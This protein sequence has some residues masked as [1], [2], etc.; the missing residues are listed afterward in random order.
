MTLQ[1]GFP[2]TVG[3]PTGTTADFGCYALLV[4]GQNIYAGHHNV[5]QWLNPAAF[6]QPCQLGSSG[7][8]VGSPAGC[9]PLSA[10]GV[11]GGAATQAHGPGFHRLDFSIFKQFK[12][13]ETTHLE[14]RSE[15]FNLTNTPQFAN[16]GFLDFTNTSTFGLITSLRDGANDPRQIQFALKFYW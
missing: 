3:C 11:L 12:T 2:F 4:P 5:N 1:D 8:I 10:L 7:P 14:F 13:S 15:F 9:A 6:N 16:P